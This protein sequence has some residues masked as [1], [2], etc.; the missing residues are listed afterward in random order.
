[1]K[2][3]P[4]CGQ[5]W[6]DEDQFC[7][8]DG[9]ALPAQESGLVGTEWAGYR[10]LAK[11]GEGG[12][13]AVYLGEHT[14]MH[15]KTAIKV[16]SQDALSTPG[17]VARF[18]REAENASRIAHPNVCTIYDF[19]ENFEGV[20]Y[21]AME[22]IE[23]E[24]LTRLV[25]REG[26]LPPHR[27]AEIVRQVADGLAAAHELSIVHRDLKPDNI[28][29][30]ESPDGT[31][32]VK[33][34]DFGIAKAMGPGDDQRVTQT[35]LAVGTPAYMSPE[36][37][38]GKP[39]D[40]RT[41]IYSLGLVFFR[42][43]TGRLPFDVPDTEMMMARLTRVPMTLA[44]AYADD[45]FSPALQQ[46]IDL[47]LQQ[48]PDDRCRD[49]TTFRDAVMRAVERGDEAPTV[50]PSRTR[51]APTIPKES[52]PVDEARPAALPPTSVPEPP[53][54]SEAQPV[55]RGKTKFLAVAAAVIVLG[56]GGWFG[57][58]KFLPM[59]GGDD[60]A[61]PLQGENSEAEPNDPGSPPPPAV[62]G[63]S[64]RSPPPV[65]S[66]TSIP[67][68]ADVAAVLQSGQDA[69]NRADAVL[70]TVGNVVP[71]L[72]VDLRESD[73]R[74][75]TLIAELNRAMTS[76]DDERV[77][78]LV[79]QLQSA[80]GELTRRAEAATL[81][82]EAV[83]SAARGRRLLGDADRSLQMLDDRLP[84]L[85]GQ[86]RDSRASVQ[87]L[88]RQIDQ[89]IATGTVQELDGLHT[90][91]EQS[92][93]MLREQIGAAGLNFV[94]R[95]FVERDDGVV[96]ATAFA[97]R[98]DGI[99]L[100]TKHVIVGQTGTQVAGRIGI[101]FVGSEQVFPAT[102]LALSPDADMALVRAQSI[103]SVVPT[104]RGF[105]VRADTLIGSSAA[106]IGVSLSRP[107][108]VPSRT[109]TLGS[110][111][112]AGP[113]RFELQGRNRGP[114][115]DG[116]A[117][118]TSGSPILDGNGEVIGVLFGGQE[119]GRIVLGGLA[120]FAVDLLEGR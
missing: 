51:D 117:E 116:A 64:D 21:L 29:V 88:T 72:A 50:A 111:R 25:E 65:R 10:I 43:L 48:D 59:L 5:E 61:L 89:A 44:E 96:D 34:V 115:F 15:R 16:M 81:G 20:L 45:E 91:L 76:Q 108:S 42:M 40:G 27:A 6:P 103:A 97:V 78:T 95:I 93:E 70:G 2:T 104:V 58:T 98:S 113:D 94:A 3:C 26:R 74:T 87:T 86:I 118:G 62:S 24:S 105:N 9:T 17:A 84:L 77:A 99:L 46:A 66:N 49:V 12:M 22:F 75:A 114:F 119:G 14:R 36:Q 109:V 7:L 4:S 56:S 37:L 68:G 32:V 60:A 8:N 18:N 31:P 1:M 100:T 11:L 106:V 38:L 90:R 110:I 57:A 101:Q 102:V 83:Q 120:R 92:A 107:E 52:V 47:A 73:T 41:D 53:I 54:T 63:A 85:A 35:G 23:G 33:V 55:R 28:M 13:G 71:R 82:Y 67:S 80:S 112:A 69:R 39:V 79:S 30:A 19:G